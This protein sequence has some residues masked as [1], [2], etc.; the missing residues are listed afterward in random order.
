MGNSPA[1]PDRLT[2]H[3][4]SG[5]LGGRANEECRWI[6]LSGHPRGEGDNCK[7]EVSQQ[8]ENT[9]SSVLFQS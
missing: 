1:P 6:A 7:A 8:R 5:A 4:D 9:M 2:T 3:C